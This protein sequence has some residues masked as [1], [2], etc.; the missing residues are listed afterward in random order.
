MTIEPVKCPF[1]ED[2]IPQFL[3][4]HP[5]MLFQCQDDRIELMNNFWSF[6]FCHCAT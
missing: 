4:V 2:K 1:S 5:R 6:D 3:I